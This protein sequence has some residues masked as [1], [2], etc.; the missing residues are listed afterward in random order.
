LTGQLAT[1]VTDQVNW[2]QK[3]DHHQYAQEGKGPR[4]TT[5]LA[6][7]TRSDTH[8]RLPHTAEKRDIRV[9]SALAVAVLGFFVVTLDAFVVNVALPAMGHELGGGITG[10]QWVVDGYTL[11]FAAMLLSAGALSDR[12]G[13]RRA[14]GIGL[15]LFVAASA[16][17]GLAP[18]IGVLIAAR[19]VQGA[20]AA[21]LLPATLALIRQAY[22]EP[23]RRARA[24]ALWSLGAGVASA[25]GPVIGGF[26][27]VLS[28][29]LI[30][31]INLPVGVVAVLLLVRVARSP[32]RAVPFDWVGQVAA[33]VGIGALTYGLIEG[34]AKGFAAPPV[35]GMLA[36]A[37][38]A[39]IVFLVAEARGDHPVV[40]LQ[41]F[42]S[43]P[44]AVSVAVGF[45]FAAGFYGLVFL[46]SLYFQELRGLSPAAAGLAFLPMTAL[47]TVMNPVA[48][49]IAERFGRR[50]SMAVG[51]T[52]MAAGLFCLGVAGG[53]GTPVVLLSALTL[54]VGL[55]AA[56]TIPT[57]TALLVDSV[58]AAL[59][60]TASGVLNTSRQLGGGL[61]VAVFGALIAYRPAFVHGLQVS[62]LIAVLL[63][64]GTAV[65][66][67]RLR[68]APQL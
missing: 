37:A 56:L 11:M 46:F 3:S 8:P 25:A 6:E 53:L 35:V 10:Q 67:L 68:S 40:P 33:V 18:S 47:G 52:F 34:S 64:M 9:R 39:L 60:G 12:I 29:R 51:Q 24:I 61:A 16:A 66:S 57:M 32:R 13:A 26:L 36:L 15:A 21:A 45:S 59:V 65:A 1:H 54:L 48:P 44:V 38:V 31:F 4:M 7:K 19:L 42:R 20:G 23:A 49:R 27:T 43:L 14:F 55:G 2:R 5:M 17:C 62:L 30:F 63:L 58:P 50:V 28:W 41:M 22:A